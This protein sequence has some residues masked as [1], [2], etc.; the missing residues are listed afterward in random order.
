MGRVRIRDELRA[1]RRLD[2]HDPEDRIVIINVM[3]L[4]YALILP[5]FKDYSYIL[6]LL[7]TYYMIVHMRFTPVFPFVYG[8]CVLSC[9][10][11][12][13]RDSG[14]WCGPYGTSIHSLWRTVVWYLYV[15]E[16]RIAMMQ[17]AA[18]PHPHRRRPCVGNGP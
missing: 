4:V 11:M 15:R 13:L 3:C 16:I 8:L 6:L 1:L 9:L 17:G 14:P 12:T 5:R 7:P 10:Y 2:V 18:P